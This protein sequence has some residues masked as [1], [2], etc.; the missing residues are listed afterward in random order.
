MEDLVSVSYLD[1]YRGER[2][3]VTGHTGFK[4]SWLVMWLAML[5]AD[6]HGL[7]LPPDSVPSLFEVA[8][9]GESVDSRFADIRELAQV[10]DIMAETA[11]RVV[12]HLAAQ[13]LVRR[14]YD[15]PVETFATNLLGTVHVLE[16]VRRCPSVQAVVVVTS[17]KCY[18]NPADGNDRRET[19]PMGGRDPYSAS[20][21]CAEL[22]TAAYRESFFAGEAAP[23]VA[24]VRAG[25]VIGGGDWAEDRLIPDVMRALTAGTSIPIRNPSHVRPWQHVMEPLR[26]YL[27]LGSLLLQKERSMAAAWNLGPDQQ[28]AVSVGELVDLAVAQWGSGSV[29]IRREGESPPEATD[30]RLDITKARKDLGFDPALDLLEAVELTVDWYRSFAE[31]PTDARRITERQLEHYTQR[32]S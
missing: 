31:R 25:N 24:T 27:M 16:A 9:L 32:L 21:G 26:G 6:V 23:L 14:S 30:L 11:P 12:F 18:H 20:K 17:D 1:R 22:A 15:Y 13:S 4:G 28:S 19:D 5:G 29:E 10:V 7:A 2:V 8:V 3:L